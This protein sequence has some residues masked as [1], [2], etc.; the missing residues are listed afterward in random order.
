MAEM[1]KIQGSSVS[2]HIQTVKFDEMWHFFQ[3]KS[4]TL[5]YQSR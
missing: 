5:D 3:K 2:G 1:K 4:K